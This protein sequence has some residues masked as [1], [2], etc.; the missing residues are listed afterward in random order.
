M[1]ST[2]WNGSCA[3]EGENGFLGDWN[4]PPPE[5]KPQ[6]VRRRAEKQNFRNTC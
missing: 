5:A 6:R 4:S 2:E 1:A 3:G